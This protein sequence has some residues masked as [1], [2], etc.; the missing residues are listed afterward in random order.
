MHW[1]RR[2][3]TLSSEDTSQVYVST[4]LAA[5]R[6]LSSLR[7]PKNPDSILEREC[8]RALELGQ[9]LSVLQL[10]IVDW[11]SVVVSIGKERVA[12]TEEELEL[13]LRGTL[14]T[15]DILR[16][17][18]GGRFVV[19][20]PGTQALDIVTVA[21]NLRQAVRSYRIVAPD[22]ATLFL[23]L[24]PRLAWASLPEEG[25]AA[26]ELLEVLENRLVQERQNPP[27]PPD[28]DAENDQRPELRLVA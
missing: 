21:Q 25:L 20:L 28:E 9:A 22:G 14:R 5:A 4:V 6:L 27:P 15:T 12:Q 2:K 23:R 19:I 24:S 1:F 11:S 26:S 7:H 18:T 10:E 17:E 8:Q 13:I 3:S 16:R